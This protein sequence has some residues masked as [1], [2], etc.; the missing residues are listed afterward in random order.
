[1]LIK[2]AVRG[3]AAAVI[4][5]LCYTP[6]HAGKCSGKMFNPITD[7]A[8]NGMWPLKIGEVVSMGGGDLPDSSDGT[9]PPINF[10]RVSTGIMVGMDISFWNIGYL[11][12][13]VREAWCSPFLGTSFNS[14]DNGWYNG[15]NSSRVAAPGT[16]KQVHWVKFP[17]TSILGLVRSGGTC[18]SSP[19]GNAGDI[20]VDYGM[21]SEVDPSHNDGLVAAA[22]EPRA[23]LYANPLADIACAASSLIA[24]APGQAFAPIYDSL[25]WCWWDNI[26]PIS[27]DKYSPHDLESAAHIGGKQIYR[28]YS[29]RVL[30]DNAKDPCRT[31]YTMI[32]KKSHWRMQASKPV[33][34]S[35]PFV[36]GRSELL[37]GVGLNPPYKDGN[38]L[39]VLFQKQRCLLRLKGASATK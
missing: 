26:Y 31:T 7:V 6:A 2:T 35:Q 27:G 8:W 12:E 10:C 32:P 28:Y 17:L 21:M 30:G 11:E 9:G 16:F 38:F 19:T 36:P 25:H 33:K 4:A 18:V 37:M 24:Q 1:M 29:Y 20:K 3:I 22:V 34:S 5:I 13:V 39:F 23:I 15:K 14:L